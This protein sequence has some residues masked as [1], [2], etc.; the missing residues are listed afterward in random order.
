[1]PPLASA[2]RHILFPSSRSRIPSSDQSL[3]FLISP[4]AN[5]SLADVTM[6][7][8]CKSD[9]FPQIRYEVLEDQANLDDKRSRTERRR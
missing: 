5:L 3:H 2:E 6:L 8:T 1:M 9:S 4:R 7:E